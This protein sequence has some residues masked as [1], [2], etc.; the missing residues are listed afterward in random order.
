[1]AVAAILTDTWISHLLFVGGRRQ[2]NFGAVDG[3]W[4]G[5]GSVLGDNTG[6]NISISCRLSEERKEDW[7]YVVQDVDLTVN[8]DFDGEAFVQVNTGPLIPTATAVTNPTFNQGGAMKG[9]SNNAIAMFKLNSAG[10]SPFQG[11]PVFGDKKI[12]G[13]FLMIAGAFG[14]N[15]DGATHTLSAW[16]WLINYN[17]FFRNVDPRVG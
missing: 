11:M 15:T 7:V 5:V 4:Y 12:A 14:T 1:M 8:A 9:I 17:S 13:V 6:G 10:A 2:T 16:G 3:I